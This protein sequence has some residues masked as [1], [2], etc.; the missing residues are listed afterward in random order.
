MTP[1]LEAAFESCLDKAQ[2]EQQRLH[3]TFILQDEGKRPT[4]DAI[5]RLAELPIEAL[6][7]EKYGFIGTSSWTPIS[8][9]LQIKPDAKPIK[10]PNPL[11]ILVFV[12]VLY[13]IAFY[14]FGMSGG[15]FALVRLRRPNI[16]QVG[17]NWKI[18]AFSPLTAQPT[19]PIIERDLLDPMCLFG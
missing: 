5:I 1:R 16:F 12:P 3:I 4:D 17:A 6:F 9:S 13:T 19:L 11:R 10:M 14:V 15:L 2:R 8:R 7:T 18:V